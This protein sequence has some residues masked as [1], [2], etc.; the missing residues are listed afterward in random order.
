MDSGTSSNEIRQGVYE[1]HFPP[2][3]KNP[4]NPFQNPK[5]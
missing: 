3:K 1:I 2:H 5:D 4:A